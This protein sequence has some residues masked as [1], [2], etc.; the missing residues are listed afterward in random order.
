[1]A[2]DG[3]IDKELRKDN[4]IQVEGWVWNTDGLPHPDSAEGIRKS[5]WRSGMVTV[6]IPDLA[7]L[8]YI[9]VPSG[10]IDQC[11][12]C[13]GRTIQPPFRCGIPEQLDSI[14]NHHS[15]TKKRMEIPVLKCHHKERVIKEAPRNQ[16]ILD[17][18]AKKFPE[19][20]NK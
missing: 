17:E 9:R 13:P 10:D 6:K 11:A 5:G 1:M 14:V 18:M 2:R 12:D 3:T 15:G 4:V 16:Q 20:E 19:E 7:A 8:G